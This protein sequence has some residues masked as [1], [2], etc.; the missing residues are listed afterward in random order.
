MV[1]HIVAWKLQD[2]AL[3]QDRAVNARLV[4]EKLE[5]L[6]GRI[7]GLVKIEVGIQANPA[8]T[9]SDVVLVSQFETWAAL[10]V[11]QKHPEHL[12]A[13]EFIGQV[14]ADRRCVDWES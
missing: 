11:Y 10:E 1:N 7:P 4:K 5:A 9:A 6:A 13:A 8:E 14:R 2:R 3:G 12:V